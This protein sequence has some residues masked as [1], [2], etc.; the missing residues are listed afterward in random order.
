MLTLPITPMSPIRTQEMKQ[1][2]DWIYQIKWDGVRI[3]THIKD[4]KV[5]L[6]SKNGLPKETVYPEMADVFAN[7]KGEFICDGE[8]IVFND[9]TQKPDFSAILQ[10]EKSKKIS[11]ASPSVTYVLFDLLMMEGKDITKLPFSQRHEHLQ[12]SFPHKTSQCFITDVFTDGEALWQW[13]ETHGWEGVICKKSGS[14][15]I[16][17][18][19]HTAWYKKKRVITLSVHLTAVEVRG[20]VIK[21]LQM[22]YDGQPIG[23]VS[24]GLNGSMREAI[25]QHIGEVVTGKVLLQPPIS[26]VVQGLEF[27]PNGSLRHPQITSWGGYK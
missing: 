11:N 23:H 14:P 12:A 18:K 9:Q 10:R 8:M 26:A 27:T 5:R 20:G 22:E 3:I 13:V 7:V 19:R 6:Y 2:Q 25:K 16:E 24:I 15:Y 1:G 21:S 4:G 17:G